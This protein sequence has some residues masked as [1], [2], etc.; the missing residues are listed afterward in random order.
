MGLPELDDDE[1]DPK[2]LEGAKE[3]IMRWGFG[4]T[5][6]MVV[7][8]PALSLPAGCASSGECGVFSKGYFAMWVAIAMIWGIV[9]TLVIVIRPVYESVDDI[10]A[11]M[12]GMMSGE[13]VDNKAIE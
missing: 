11:V 6:V 2:V 5:F 8:W 7:A 4:F 9:A 13:V 12:Q 1:K 3:W 10:M